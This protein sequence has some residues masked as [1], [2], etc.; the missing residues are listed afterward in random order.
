M[1]GSSP[2]MT[3][4]CGDAHFADLPGVVYFAKSAP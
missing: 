1:A 3:Q 2:A 4:R